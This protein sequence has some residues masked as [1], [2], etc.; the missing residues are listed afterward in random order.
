MN[1]F[2]CKNCGYEIDMF[3]DKK[4]NGCNQTGFIVMFSKEAL[5][6][7]EDLTD[8]KPMDKHIV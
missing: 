8:Y 4:C 2:K 3:N 6:P 7:A 5:A 1:K